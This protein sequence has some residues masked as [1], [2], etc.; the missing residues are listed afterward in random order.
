MEATAAAVLRLYGDIAQ[1]PTGKIEALSG[2]DIALSTSSSIVGGV[3][4]LAKGTLLQGGAA[5]SITGTTAIKNAGEIL[6]DVSGSEFTINSPIKNASTGTLVA[7]NNSLLIC[8]GAVTKGT[9]QIKD[10][11]KVYFDGPSSANVTFAS[12]GEPELV[13]TNPSE[14]TGTVA[15]M[16]ANSGAS[17]DLEYIPFADDPIVSPLSAKGVLTVTD[18]VTHVIDTIKIVGGGTFTATSGGI[19]G[20]TLIEDPPAN[21]AGVPHTNT[22]LLAQSMASFGA[23]GS[24]AGSGTSALAQ[25]HSSS[26]F[27]AANSHHG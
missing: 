18:P 23:S 12:G 4:S 13:L 19:A 6:S 2:G 25:N 1:N 20:S 17:I 24:I 14:F 16:A 8:T 26:D 9:V 7:E 27:L 3:V 10:T 15:G 11:S 22:N 21:A 5:S